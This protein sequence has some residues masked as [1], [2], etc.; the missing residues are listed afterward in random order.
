MRSPTVN[1]LGLEGYLPSVLVDRSAVGRVDAVAVPVDPLDQSMVAGPSDGVQPR[2][3]A[4]LRK[5]QQTHNTA[6]SHRLDG[7][8]GRAASDDHFVFNCNFN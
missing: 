4:T 6:V 8:R 1:D 3:K 5:R 2:R 7:E